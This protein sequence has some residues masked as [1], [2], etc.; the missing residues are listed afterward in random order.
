M[1]GGPSL[2]EADPD[3]YAIMKQEELRQVRKHCHFLKAL[4]SSIPPSFPTTLLN[5]VARCRLSASSTAWS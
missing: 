4:R 5:Y 1:S 3:L 2:Q